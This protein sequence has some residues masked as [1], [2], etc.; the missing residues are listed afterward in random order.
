MGLKSVVFRAAVSILDNRGASR[1]GENGFCG[2]S[3]NKQFEYDHKEDSAVFFDKNYVNRR[4]EANRAAFE[5]LKERAGDYAGPA[6]VVT[7]GEADFMPAAGEKAL[8]LSPEQERLWVEFRSRAGALQREYIPGEETS[9]TCI[10]FP[11]PE[12]GPV[13]EEL[14]RET[15]RIN[16]LDYML[17]RRVQQ[18]LIDTLDTADYCEVRGTGGNRT[19]LRINLWKLS[20]PEKET[21]F[22]NCV[23]DVNIP[24]GEVFTSPVLEG[25]EGVLHVKSAFLRGMEYK[26]LFLSFEN[27]MVTDYGC[28]NFDAEEENRAFVREHILARHDT[29][30]MGEFAIGTNTTAYV[31]AKRLGVEARLPVLI[32]EKMGPHFA[33]GDTCYAHSEEVKV[34]NPDG[35]E[36]VAK[37]NAVSDMRHTKPLEAYYNCHTDV[38]IPYDELGELTAVRRDGTRIVI[39][40]DGRFVLPGCEELNKAFE[41]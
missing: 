28:A 18:N 6:V 8:K 31:A 24:V 15:I 26:D 20:D 38:T 35:R 19:N 7:F 16:T 41:K 29:L 32:G 12:I 1:S 9:F 25:T 17:Y 4:L 36:I 39:I 33:V 5:K 10:A 3:P 2:G 40:R 21:I 37:S 34:Y 27:G 30:P 23:A 13:F 22:E 14:F 11:L